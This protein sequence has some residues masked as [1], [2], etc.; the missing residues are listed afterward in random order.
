MV[1]LVWVL[2]SLWVL[3]W[4]LTSLWVFDLKFHY[5]L[6]LNKQW[7]YHKIFSN[8]LGFWRHGCLVCV[9]FLHLWA[10]HSSSLSPNLIAM[11]PWV[12]VQGNLASAEFPLFPHANQPLNSSHHCA[13]VNLNFCIFFISY[14]KHHLQTQNNLYISRHQHFLQ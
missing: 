10:L 6:S 8:C 2:T 12:I 13:Y 9:C 5:E 14:I 3:I 4:V 11:V 7:Q 1:L